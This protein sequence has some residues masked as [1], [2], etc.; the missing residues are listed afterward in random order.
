[1]TPCTH[2]QENRLGSETAGLWSMQMQNNA[3][4]FPKGVVPIDN[5]SR[6]IQEVLLIHILFNIDISKQLRFYYGHK[7]LFHCG[8]NLHFPEY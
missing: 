5:H 4:L 1:M 2:V 6:D 3:K 7:I 8:L